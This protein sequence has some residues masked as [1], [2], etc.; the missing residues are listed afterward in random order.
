MALDL[1][2]TI[3]FKKWLS[4]YCVVLSA[5]API[6]NLIV[7]LMHCI[8]TTQ[9][10]ATRQIFSSVPTSFCCQHLFDNIYKL[11]FK[12]NSVSFR[13][14]LSENQ[15]KI[16]MQMLVKIC[17]VSQFDERKYVLILCTWK[18]W[19]C[20]TNPFKTLHTH[21]I[22]N[23]LFK[24]RNLYLL[25]FCLTYNLNHTAGL[26]FKAMRCVVSEYGCTWTLY[27]GRI[28]SKVKLNAYDLLYCQRADQNCGTYDTI[29]VCGFV[30]VPIGC[31]WC[32]SI[33]YTFQG[34]IVL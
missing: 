3:L 22:F 6:C 10:R 19:A 31:G 21:F 24:K 9:I 5:D 29:T 2:L 13:C 27:F 30:T 16:F 26:T 12:L 25:Q 33:I 23:L 1:H 18:C 34:N 4:L 17:I 32:R 7:N 14:H 15:D 28:Y 11:R 20:L 8:F